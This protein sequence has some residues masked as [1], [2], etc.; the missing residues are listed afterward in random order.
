[1]DSTSLLHWRQD[2]DK[3]GM[4]IL[5]MGIFYEA[6]MRWVGPASSVTAITNIFV[7]QRKEAESG[8][9]IPIQIP[10]HVDIIAEM[11]C[12]A[13][14]RMQFSS[15]LG[16]VSPKAE[17]S[18]FGSEGTLKLDLESGQLFI[19]KK[20]EDKMTL[21]EIPAS[22]QQH[23]RVEEEFVSAIRGNEKISLTT[24]EDGVKYMEFTEAV[25]RSSIQK[26]TIAL[27]LNVQ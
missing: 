27:P 8:K 9:T 19:G 5:S 1:M 22:D 3:S 10:D 25:W 17:I 4:N 7:K 21:Y 2:I 12:G 11:A 15:V 23:W 6:L 14:A 26:K 20:G 13:Q 18:L 16:L 24:F